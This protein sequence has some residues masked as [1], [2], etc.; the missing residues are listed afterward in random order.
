MSHI[1]Y[2]LDRAWPANTSTETVYTD[3]VAPLIHTVLDGHGATLLCMGQTGTGKTYTICGLVKCLA[4][5]LR[6]RA[7]EVEFFEICG[8]HCWD[9]LAARKPLRLLSDSKV[10]RHLNPEVTC[11]C[12]GKQETVFE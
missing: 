9:L 11:R 3:V 10:L 4:R 1:R 7:V 8:R 2:A 12:T 6:G 5:E